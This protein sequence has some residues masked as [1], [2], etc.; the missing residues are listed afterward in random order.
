[1]HKT[2]RKR[3]AFRKGV[4]QMEAAIPVPQFVASNPIQDLQSSL[5]RGLPK[6]SDWEQPFSSQ[7]SSGKGWLVGIDCNVDEDGRS[8]WPLREVKNVVG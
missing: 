6:H 8:T 1:M 2:F 3:K 7:G 4:E 5:R